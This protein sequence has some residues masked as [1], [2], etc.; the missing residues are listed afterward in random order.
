TNYRNAAEIFA[1]AAAVIRDAEPDLALPSAVRRAGTE[2]EN[3]RVPVGVLPEAARS[4]AAELLDA[5]E[6]TVGVIT[7]MTRRDEVAGWLADLTGD[8]L[9]VVGSLE[10]KGMEYD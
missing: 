8:R 6:G 2:P 7:P 1:L 4:A 10:A 9:Q 3:R 5:V